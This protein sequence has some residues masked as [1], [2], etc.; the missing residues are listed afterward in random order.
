MM[1]LWGMIYE[2]QVRRASDKRR[3]DPFSPL[4][5]MITTRFSIV[6]G[7]DGGSGVFHSIRDAIVLLLVVAVVVGHYSNPNQKQN[8]RHLPFLVNE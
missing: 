2:P 8:S 1:A 6:M 3:K 5:H 7:S 4:S